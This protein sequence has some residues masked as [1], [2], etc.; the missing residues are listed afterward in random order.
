[1]GINDKAFRLRGLRDRLH[2]TGKYEPTFRQKIDLIVEI[3]GIV[4]SPRNLSWCRRYTAKLRDQNL[5]MTPEQ[6]QLIGVLDDR[7]FRKG[8]MIKSR[9]EKKKAKGPKKN[10]PQPPQPAPA[11]D[12]W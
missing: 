4:H 7:L 5:E 8:E 2:Q 9:Q 11:E 6:L 10:G 3:L 1:M 12:V